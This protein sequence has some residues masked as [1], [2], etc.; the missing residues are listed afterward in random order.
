MWL[1]EKFID[2]EFEFLS[3]TYIISELLL[4]LLYWMI[5]DYVP[6]RDV[7]KYAPRKE[8]KLGIDI[9]TMP[10][11]IKIGKVLLSLKEGEQLASREREI[12]ELI[13]DNR[14]RREIAEEEI[15]L[16]KNTVKTY[17]RT[18]YSKLGVTS[19]EELYALL[20]H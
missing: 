11:D 15:H 20:L 16:S 5:Q 9:A 3:V 1:F 14:K 4:L 10:M 6:L 17:T 12:L 2:W 18:L 19:R 13:L 8:E 7:H